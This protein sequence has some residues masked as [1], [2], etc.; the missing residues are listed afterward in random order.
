MLTVHKREFEWSQVVREFKFGILTVGN[1][2]RNGRRQ[3]IYN[4]VFRGDDV[5]VDI[6]TFIFGGIEVQRS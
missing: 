3:R 6:V 2:H 5:S 1:P 4:F